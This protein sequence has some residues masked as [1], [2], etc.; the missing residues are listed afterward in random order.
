LP[1]HPKVVSFVSQ[2]IGE[3]FVRYLDQIFLK[4]GKSGAGTQWH[5]DNAYFKI[6]DPT[7]GIGMWVALHDATIANGT[8]HMLPGVYRQTFE[9]ARDMGSDHHIIMQADES[10]AV[11]IELPAGGAIFFNFGV[12]HCTKANT[13]D[14]ERAGLAY[15]FLCT[16]F[17]PDRVGFG[18]RKELIHV[19]GSEASGGFNEYGVKVEGTWVDEVAKLLTA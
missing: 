2:I 8:M 6:G 16:D 9:H 4:P 7:K 10:K 17:V 15:H 13:T 5:T 19:T 1:Y 11:P 3:P 18:P 12:P 14:K